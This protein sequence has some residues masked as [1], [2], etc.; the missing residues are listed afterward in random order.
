MEIN[1]CEG[2][3]LRPH[4]LQQASRSQRAALHRE[5]GIARPFAYGIQ[6]INISVAELEGFTFNIRACNLRLKDGTRL[7][8]PHNGEFQPRSFKK[9]LDAAGGVLDVYI[10]L[11]LLMEREPNTLLLSEES[12]I[13]HRRYKAVVSEVVDENTG[14]NGQAIEFRKYSPRIFFRGE[15]TTGYETLQIARIERS[16]FEENKPILSRNFIPP[17]L[18]MEAWPPLFDYCK[19][20]YQQ[21]VAKNRSLI[22]Q[23]AGRKIAFG[24]EGVGG[25]EAM[26]KLNITNRYV[27]FLRQWTSMPNLHPFDVYVELCRLAGDLAIFDEGRAAPELPLYNHD[28]LGACYLDLL[29]LLERLI[30]NILPTTFIKRRFEPVENRREVALEDEWLLPEVEFYL[31]IESDQDDDAIDRQVSYL[32]MGSVEDLPTLIN[33]RLPGLML[34]RVRRTPIGLPDR[35]NYHFYRMSREGR[36]W[37]SLLQTKVLASY[38]LADETLELDLY[39]LLKPE[40]EGD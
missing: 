16:G 4:H 36:F 39:I 31:C 35:P 5:I 27:A 17:I 25:P 29:R 13:Y 2:M 28:D 1:W 20:I 19:D 38:G 23:I 8:A 18:V 9:E 15:D 10:G 7:I 37:D 34:R 30:N 22:S 26:L 33:R 32:K 14:S 21:L 40:Y 11:P 6:Q 12:S 3:F 24:S